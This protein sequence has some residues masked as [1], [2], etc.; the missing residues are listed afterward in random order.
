VTLRV[1]TLTGAALPPLLPALAALR[2]E[3]FREWPYLYDGSSDYEQA[4]LR[5][6]AEA[7]DAAMVVAF[8][9]DRP[10]GVATCLPMAAASEGV[11]APFLAAG[12]DV[13]RICYFGES[14]L[15]RAWRGQ[16][17]GVAFFRG[18]EAH[19]RGIAHV[20]TAAFCAVQRPDDHPARPAGH[21]PLDAFWRKR[22]FVFHPE[23][24]ATM[25]WREIGQPEET[26]KP[27]AF[28]LKAL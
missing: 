7:P 14:V 21:V 19:A 18:R 23:L 10:V 2:T 16:G 13:S 24:V 1:E 28:W 8:D 5:R 20:D 27:L 15:L 11:I 3:V 26:E 9:G 6:Y 12:R 17:I 4:Y 25:S 22:G